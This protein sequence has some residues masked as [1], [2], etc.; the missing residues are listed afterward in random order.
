MVLCAHVLAG[1]L[2]G[3]WPSE[4][5]IHKSTPIVI[6][7]DTRRRRI[8]TLPNYFSPVFFPIVGQ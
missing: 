6:N 1:N 4:Q 7:S 8:D 3:P 2:L 5:Y